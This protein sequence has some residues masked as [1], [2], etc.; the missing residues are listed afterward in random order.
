MGR[1]G[2]DNIDVIH[3]ILS[4]IYAVYHLLVIPQQLQD[5]HIGL[6]EIMD[7]VWLLYIRFSRTDVV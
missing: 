3:K 5:V 4:Y 6:W 1:E 7:F 2:E